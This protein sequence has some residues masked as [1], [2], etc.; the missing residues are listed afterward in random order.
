MKVMSLGLISSIIFSIVLARS[1]LGSEAV[2][3][4]VFPFCIKKTKKSHKT[5]DEPY[6]SKDAYDPDIPNIKFIDEFSPKVIEI[7]KVN[8]PRLGELFISET[9]GTIVDKAPEFLRREYDPRRVGWYIRPYEEDYE[10]MIKVI[11]IPLNKNDQSFQFNQTNVHKQD[12]TTSAMLKADEKQEF[13]KEQKL[14][15]I[16]EEDSS[17]LHEDAEELDK[18]N[19]N[20]D[21]DEELDRVYLRALSHLD[22]EED[23][24]EKFKENLGKLYRTLKM[25]R[26]K[27]RR[28]EGKGNEEN[29][30]KGEELDKENDNEDK[31]EELDRVYLRA[32]SHLDD[33][34]DD[35]EKFKENL[36]KLYRTLKIIRRKQRR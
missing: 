13:P 1:T 3:G 35:N 32:L 28:N 30:N 9:N 16:N 26:R 7:C 4:C 21:K 2:T 8:Q 34:E 19:D 12:G 25:I 14:S 10:H 17:I 22:D 27:R 36:G 23:D 24:N 11:F 29:E 15:I 20:E 31:D 5:T 18:E 6:K 33:E